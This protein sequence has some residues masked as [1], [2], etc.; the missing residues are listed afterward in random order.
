MTCE[1]RA[2]V[3]RSLERLTWFLWHGNVYQALQVIQTIEGDREVT[4]ATRVIA[5]RNQFTRI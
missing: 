3:V 5:P 1:V 4:V 2:P